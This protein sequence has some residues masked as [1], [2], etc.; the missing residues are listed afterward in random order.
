MA[1]QRL[2]TLAARGG[3][4]D[5]FQTDWGSSKDGACP[6]VIGVKLLR[7]QTFVQREL[8]VRLSAHQSSAS[9]LSH[10]QVIKKISA[11]KQ[12][13]RS[14]LKV[15]TLFVVLLL[16]KRVCRRQ[17]AGAAALQ[18]DHAHTLAA[19]FRRRRQPLCVVVP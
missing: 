1:S 14:S 19:C 4:C 16:S 12:A 7:R 15:S 6:V 8:H 9:V 10:V 2:C 3:H 11:K 13:K 18:R 17:A 5:I